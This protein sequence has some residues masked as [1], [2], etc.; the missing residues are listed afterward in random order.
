LRPI[1]GQSFSEQA[2]S[3]ER[4]PVRSGDVINPIHNRA[5]ANA[6]KER[7]AAALDRLQG[8]PNPVHWSDPLGALL[9]AADAQ[10]LAG[11]GPKR[12]I[13]VSNGYLQTPEYNIFRFRANPIS[14]VGP[15]LRT[16]RE[17]HTL[18]ALS[19]TDVVIVGVTAGASGMDGTTGET[20]GVCR[21][22]EAIVAAGHGTLVYCGRGLP[23]VSGA[24]P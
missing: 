12:I 7:E 5:E 13:I 8:Y 11:V 19:G 3:V 9:V 24:M 20:R 2:I 1:N 16:L 21:F 18:P 17:E 23:D 10:R 4:I 22:W 6:F 14:F 15:V